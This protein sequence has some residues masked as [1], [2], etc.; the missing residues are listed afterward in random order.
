MEPQKRFFFSYLVYPQT[1]DINQGNQY[2]DNLQSDRTN[3]IDV[4][5]YKLR[6]TQQ[7]TTRKSFKLCDK[8]Y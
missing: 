6:Y 5:I 8:I 2:I 7:M 3:D 1:L 4:I